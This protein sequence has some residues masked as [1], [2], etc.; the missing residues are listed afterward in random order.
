MEG[1][2]YPQFKEFNDTYSSPLR[3]MMWG[4]MNDPSKR[5]Y[6]AD[7]VNAMR[8]NAT[9]AIAGQKQST[10]ANVKKQ[11]AASG[12]GNTGMATHM[13]RRMGKDAMTQQRQAN[14][15]VDLAQAEAQRDDLWKA[16]QGYGTAANMN[17]Q[18]R[19][20]EQNYW[21]QMNKLTSDYIGYAQ[22]EPSFWNSF[23]TSFGS[24]LGKTLGS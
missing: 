7:T 18:N 6:S 3:D 12:M 10:E 16:T 4:M 1:N 21:N 20:G 15:D 2:L 14:R 22:S 11:I 9:D 5:G 8:A 23:K 24:S 17:L 19:A 13:A